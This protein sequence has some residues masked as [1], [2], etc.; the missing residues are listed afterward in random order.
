MSDDEVGDCEDR[1][2]ASV[3]SNSGDSICRGVGGFEAVKPTEGQ[4]L[5]MDEGEFINL[6]SEAEKS[7]TDV[8]MEGGTS[9]ANDRAICMCTGSQDDMRTKPIVCTPLAVV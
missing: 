5:R 1:E 2:G 3:V 7:R 9:V 4:G 6:A 8:A